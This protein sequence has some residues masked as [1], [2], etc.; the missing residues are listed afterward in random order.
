MRKETKTR[1]EVRS[2]RVKFISIPFCSCKK[3]SSMDA[4]FLKNVATEG[5]T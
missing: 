5:I 2:R 1:R 3:G 4:C